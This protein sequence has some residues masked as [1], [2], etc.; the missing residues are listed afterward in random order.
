MVYSFSLEYFRGDGL[1]IEWQESTTLLWIA[2]ISRYTPRVV[3]STMCW[4][5]VWCCANHGRCVELAPYKKNRLAGRL[6]LAA[7]GIILL[8]HAA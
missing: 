3:Q 7:I 5:D 2:Y 4:R 1:S 6:I 8:S